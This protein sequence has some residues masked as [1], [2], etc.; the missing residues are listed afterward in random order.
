MK[1][2]LQ[3]QNNLRLIGEAKA[4]SINDLKNR[5]EIGEQF[6]L[7]NPLHAVA[8]EKLRILKSVLWDKMKW[9]P[10]ED[11]IEKEI[12]DPELQKTLAGFFD[13]STWNK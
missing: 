1:T 11:S 4:Q 10:K 8:I 12:E 7:N 13:E 3:M 6:I 2:L 5:I 9:Q